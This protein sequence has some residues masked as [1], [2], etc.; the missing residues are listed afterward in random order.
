MPFFQDLVAQHGSEAA[1]FA[2]MAAMATPLGRYA[3]A[4]EVA[5]Q[6]SHLLSDVSATVTGAALVMDGGYSL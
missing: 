6:I 2:A 3:S 4:E 5:A 1:A